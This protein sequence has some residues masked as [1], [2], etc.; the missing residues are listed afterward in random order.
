MT[1][2]TEAIENAARMLRVKETTY[3]QTYGGI[4]GISLEL[5]AAWTELAR[6]MVA[7]ERARPKDRA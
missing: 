1:T 5:G 7:A 4:G 2:T 6:V 3:K